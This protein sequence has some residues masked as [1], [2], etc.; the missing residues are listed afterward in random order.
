MFVR[1]RGGYRKRKSKIIPG[2]GTVQAGVQKE[3]Q[4]KKELLNGKRRNEDPEANDTHQNK[5][6]PTTGL[7]MEGEAISSV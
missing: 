3:Q 5:T 6:Q 7:S 4:V 2:S 1:K